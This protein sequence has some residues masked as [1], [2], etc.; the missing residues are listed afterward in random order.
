M[1]E[2][3]VDGMTMKVK[4]RDGKLRAP[5]EA[6]MQQACSYLSEQGSNVVTLYCRTENCPKKG[7]WIR[8]SI[9]DSKKNIYVCEG[10]CKKPMIR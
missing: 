2:W 5:T 4:E 8:R 10:G 6:E 7:S 3:V 9:E 1:P